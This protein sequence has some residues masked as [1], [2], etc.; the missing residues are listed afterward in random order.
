VPKGIKPPAA[1]RGR[2]KGAQNKLGKAV[3]DV[4]AAAAE[5]LGGQKRLVEWAKLDPKNES[6]FWATIYPKLLPLQLTGEG[7]GPIK[8]EVDHTL[9]PGDAYQRMLNG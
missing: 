6:A 8:A 3:K 5:E 4:I 7:G 2:P 1:G 9:A